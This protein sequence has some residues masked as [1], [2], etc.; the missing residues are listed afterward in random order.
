M[1]IAKQKA[2]SLILIDECEGALSSNHSAAVPAMNEMW[3]DEGPMVLIVGTT[4][5]PLVLQ[6]SI[7][8]RFGGAIKFELPPPEVYQDIVERRVRE[9]DGKTPAHTLQMSPSDWEW[10]LKRCKG[11][12][13]RQL[14][15]LAERAMALVRYPGG[16]KV[17]APPPI[18]LADFKEVIALKAPASV[19]EEVEEE[20][21]S[22]SVED[23]IKALEWMA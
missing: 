1:G 14:Q 12:D 7:A 9:G 21:S 17:A 15:N 11:K 10:L 22:M 18:K 6:E 3:S 13:T 4:N 16:E 5:K 19:D 20:E 8:S 23:M 2:P